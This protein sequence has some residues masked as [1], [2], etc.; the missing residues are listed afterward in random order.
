MIH[1]DRR[2]GRPPLLTVPAPLSPAR[3]GGQ[4]YEMYS[5][6]GATRGWYRLGRGHIRK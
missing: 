5:P 2:E 1:R 6:I 3:K 4:N